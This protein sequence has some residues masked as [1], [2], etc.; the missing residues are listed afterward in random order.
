[1][2]WWELNDWQHKEQTMAF[3]V[4]FPLGLDK[5]LCCPQPGAKQ[6]LYVLY[7]YFEVICD[8]EEQRKGEVLKVAISYQV[9]LSGQ[10]AFS[11]DLTAEQMAQAE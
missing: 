1:M 2:L 5:G 8:P 4:C 9:C 10:P 11:P 3:A 6:F 7:S